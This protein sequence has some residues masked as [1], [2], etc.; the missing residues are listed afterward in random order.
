[1]K[2]IFVFL[3]LFTFS[4]SSGQDPWKNVY[5]ESAWKERDTWQKPQEIIAYLKIGSGSHVADIGCHEG[6]MTVKLAHTVGSIGNVFA[7]DVDQGKLDKLSSHLK[8]RS[9]KNVIP[10]KGDYDNPMLS[11]ALDA[12]VIIDTYHEMDAHDKILQHIIRALKPG[13]R[14]VI[15]EPIAEARRKSPRSDQ[16]RR[17]EL[18]MNYALEDLKKAGFEIVLKKDPFADRSK[19]KGDVMWLVVARKPA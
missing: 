19:I 9:I 17:H 5:T 15:C 1:M 8:D 2:W 18:G 16:E 12:V 11:E 7:V 6:Y 13:G 4:I 10:V 14:L 3:S